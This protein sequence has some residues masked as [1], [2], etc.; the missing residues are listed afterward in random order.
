MEIEG[1]ALP[2]RPAT[3]AMENTFSSFTP[4][5]H[6]NSAPPRS[7]NF[8]SDSRKPL[9]LSP[10]TGWKKQSFINNRHAELL[11][12]WFIGLNPEERGRVL[13]FED[14]DGV[15]LLKQMFDTRKKEGDGLFFSVGDAFF[16]TV[17]QVQNK[18]MLQFGAKF[19][20]QRLT[21]LLTSCFYPEL[22]LM[23]D[24]KLDESIRLCDTREYLDTITVASD[25]LEDGES[26]VRLMKIVTRG[27]FLTVPCK[28]GYDGSR[29]A[30]IWD[31]PKWY[32]DMGYYS[33]GTFIAHK[34]ETVLWMRYWDSHKIDPRNIVS[35]R[36]YISPPYLEGL[37][38]KSYLIEF[39]KSRSPQER[40]KIVGSI[41]NIVQHVLNNPDKKLKKD[42]NKVSSKLRQVDLLSTLVDMSVDEKSLE[43]LFSDSDLA[44][45]PKTFIEILYFSP[46]NRAGSAMDMV[47]RRIGISIHSAYTEKLSMELIVGEEAEKIKKSAVVKAQEA[48]KGKKKK[49]KK[50][51]TKKKKEVEKENKEDKKQAGRVQKETISSI[52]GDIANNATTKITERRNSFASSGSSSQKTSPLTAVKSSPPIVPPSPALDSPF[53]GASESAPKKPT[54]PKKKKKATEVPSRPSSSQVAAGPKTAEKAAAVAMKKSNSDLHL[55]QNE[56]KAQQDLLLQREINKALGVHVRTLSKRH[57]FTI[58]L[59]QQI[60]EFEKTNRLIIEKKYRV[61]ADSMIR[62]VQDVVNA[63]WPNAIVK[64]YGSYSTA[65][66]IPSSDLDLVVLNASV[67]NVGYPLQVMAKFLRHKPWV[68]HM[69]AIETARVPVIKLISHPENLPTD[70][71]FNG[72]YSIYGMT[73]CSSNGLYN[74]AGLAAAEIVQSYT[75]KMEPLTPLVLVLKHF[76][77]RRG[78]HNAFTG[79]L[80]SYCLVIMVISFLQVFGGLGEST[81][82]SGGAGVKKSK[83]LGALLLDFLELYGKKFDYQNMGITICNGGNHFFLKDSP[84]RYPPAA[85]YIVDPLNPSHNI[86]HH[87]F[88]MSRVKLAFEDAYNTLAELLVQSEKAP[89][90]VLNPILDELFSYKLT[91][92]SNEKLMD[93]KVRY[94]PPIPYVVNPVVH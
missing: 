22:L 56:R 39:W 71:T 10:S 53:A 62:K 34:L 76:L 75:R 87:V 8:R 82:I 41:G 94:H 3:S 2:P 90:S 38:S 65:L 86:G 15:I 12:K 91:C 13:S 4:L 30:W 44:Q 37:L 29:R 93:S 21:S 79:G 81:P 32:R 17:E 20:F 74:H 48:R 58:K 31:P 80:N 88:G 23:S 78:L 52:A 54:K 49:K 85:L 67:T 69:Q 1:A 25:L 46:L 73:Y 26:F 6:S 70:I 28:V 89:V 55:V 45:K 84:F 66:C 24:R 35:S 36:R 43:L 5:A 9:R 68:K 59:H 57:I 64:V 61:Q 42:L 60:E 7:S 72:E 50:S 92:S 33:L 18:P 27:G 11:T 47:L 83:N 19:C 63:I 77:F 51:V 40:R 14:K 16:D